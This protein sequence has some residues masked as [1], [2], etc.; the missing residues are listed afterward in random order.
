MSQNYFSGQTQRRFQRDS[1]RSEPEI[2]LTKYSV[3]ECDV[4]AIHTAIQYLMKNGESEY[5]GSVIGKLY[6]DDLRHASID[7]SAFL[8]AFRQEFHPYAK[9]STLKDGSA[10]IIIY[11]SDSQTD[12]VHQTVKNN[13]MTIRN[14]SNLSPK[15]AA[16]VSGGI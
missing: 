13:Y 2:P 8:E 3:V 9:T 14:T 7:E 1:S 4:G 12:R 11:Y 10:V 5:R 6:G 15:Q 16:F